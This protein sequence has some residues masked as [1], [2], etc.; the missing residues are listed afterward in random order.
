MPS[1]WLEKCIT[2]RTGIK[3]TEPNENISGNYLSQAEK[4]LKRTKKLIEEDDMLWASVTAYYC[5]YYSLYAFLQKTGI[6]SENHSCSIEMF[7]YLTN[8]NDLVEDINRFRESRISSQY[9]LNTPDKKII[10]ENYTVLKDFYVELHN[11]CNSEDE[12]LREVKNKIKELFRTST[13][14]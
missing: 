6:K 2:L 10:L 9:Y 12:Y 14:L 1:L 5:A 8:R 4:T 3:Q 13:K 7:R 11:L